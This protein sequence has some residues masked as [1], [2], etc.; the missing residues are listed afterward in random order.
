[1][2]LRELIR[3]AND[4]KTQQ[5]NCPEWGVDLYFR[6]MT[7]SEAIA[8]ENAVDQAPGGESGLLYLIYTLCD[9][10]GKR[11]YQPTPEDIAELGEKCPEIIS[12]L[13]K[14]AIKFNNPKDEDPKN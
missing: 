9:A 10:E 7:F 8:Y 2:N 11:I 13:F 12:S 14:Q 4:R 3:S 1:M 5:V 6:G